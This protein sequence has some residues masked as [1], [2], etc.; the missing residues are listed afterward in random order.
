[1]FHHFFQ[2]DLQNRRR[3]FWQAQIIG[4]GVMAIVPFL[5]F[6]TSGVPAYEAVAIS[7]TR[8]LISMILSCLLLLPLL[9][10]LRRQQLPIVTV[11][12]VIVACCAI[13]GWL[14]VRLFKALIPV[15]RLNIAELPVYLEE[16]WIIRAI[17]FWMWS[18]LYFVIHYWLNTQEARL[19]IAQMQVEQRTIEL[20]QL[21]A[22]MN[23]HFLFNAF[24]TILA[25]AENPQI[26]TKLTESMAEFLRFSLMQTG[27]LQEL[28]KELEALKHYLRVEKQRFEEHFEY[29]ITASKQ[30]CECQVPII[31]IHPLVENAVKYGQHTSP[32]PL[33]LKIEAK[34]NKTELW[35]TVANSGRWVPPEKTSDVGGIGLANLQRRLELIYSGNAQC[36][37]E[38]KEGWVYVTLRI[39][40]EVHI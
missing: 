14:D 21:R 38:E 12:I 10:W 31:L 5:F 7:T 29:H 39:P 28:G 25:K 16:S 26:V 15:L 30:A 34:L 37:H 8:A 3:L 27:D 35:I 33:R 19:R 9:R 40:K 32:P 22:Q 4:W 2:F 18:V 17:V 23:P 20:Q 24:N 1:M 6:H 13:L 36:T 11:G